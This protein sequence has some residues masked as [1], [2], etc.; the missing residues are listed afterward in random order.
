[1]LTGQARLDNMREGAVVFGLF[2]VALA[3]WLFTAIRTG[4]TLY[5]ERTSLPRM[6]DRQGDPV[7]Y[8]AMIVS[9]SLLDVGAI[10]GAFYLLFSK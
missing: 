10:G 2:A 4:R 8:W 1:M 6:V 5:I 7:G 3:V 9:I